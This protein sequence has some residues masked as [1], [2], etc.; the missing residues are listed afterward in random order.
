MSAPRPISVVV[1][2][3]AR[4]LQLHGYLTSLE[5]HWRGAFR[6]T[7]LVR[8]TE[9]YAAA[10]EEVYRAFPQVAFVAETDFGRDLLMALDA[11]DAPIVALA[12][13]D[14]VFVR[15]VDT[16]AIHAAFRDPALLGVS[17]RLGR[18]LTRGMFG[19][20][21]AQPV[22][23]PA[24][25]VEPE[26]DPDRPSLLWD[27]QQA[28]SN[29]DWCYAWDVAAT[30]FEG[31]FARAMVRGLV[32]DGLCTSPNALEYHGDLR[33]RAL[34]RARGRPLLRAWPSPRAVVP[35]VNVVQ[36]EYPNGIA[37]GAAERSPEELLALWQ[38]GARLDVEAFTHEAAETEWP[39]WRLGHLHLTTPTE[40]AR[41]G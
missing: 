5:R 32:A 37:P 27:A 17:F 35:T 20:P 8:V 24:A 15:P 26:H 11:I 21:M 30:A 31:E 1:F 6:V 19:H 22:F 7:A 41:H 25:G 40:V 34:S 14:V 36:S 4:P 23:L 29:T 38:R 33:W 12:C 3:K 39:T 9:P 2:S 28:P 13:D 16:A 10:Y 18:G